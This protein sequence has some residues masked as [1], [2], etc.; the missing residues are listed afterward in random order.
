M[1]ICHCRCVTQQDFWRIYS[2]QHHHWNLTKHV[3]WDYWQ[4]YELRD[5]HL[6]EFDQA[7]FSWRTPHSQKFCRS[8]VSKSEIAW[9]KC[10]S[11]VDIIKI[12][13]GSYISKWNWAI[14]PPNITAGGKIV[15]SSTK[16]SIL[17]AEK[18]FVHACLVEEG[19]VV[20]LK[21]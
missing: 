18:V 6:S 11:S 7:S 14:I 10:W 16:K 9:F 17:F 4:F 15:R 19:C 1:Q 5:S 8:P 20:V 2:F 13:S 3:K 12:I 21:F